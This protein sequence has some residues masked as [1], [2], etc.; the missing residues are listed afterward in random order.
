MANWGGG[1]IYAPD[2]LPTGESLFTTGAGSNSGSYSDPK[3]D[4]LILA[5][6]KTNGTG[7]LYEYEDYAAKQLPVIYQPTDYTIAATS[8]N[9]GGVVFNPLLTLVPEYWYRTQ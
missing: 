8:I 4:R 3:M 9:V 5:T 7:P 1:W 2:Y 6:Q